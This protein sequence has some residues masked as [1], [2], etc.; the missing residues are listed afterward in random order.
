[1]KNA[2]LIGLAAGCVAAGAPAAA[3]H[4]T[5]MFDGQ[6]ELTLT[7][8]VKDFQWTNPH[9]WIQLNVRGEQGAIEEWSIEGNSPNALARAG[10][11]RTTLKPGDQ[12]TVRIRPLKN[13]HK[14]GSFMS[15]TLPD[16]RQL[17]STSAPAP[18]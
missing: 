5:A 13:G 10:W 3:H 2:V 11:K 1:M 7:G 14:G 16:G 12:I 15:A 18:S 4:S 6:K 8:V 17:T 9:S